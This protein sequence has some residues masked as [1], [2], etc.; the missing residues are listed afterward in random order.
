MA[1]PGATR[2]S[3]D[4]A[5]AARALLALQSLRNK[6]PA[7]SKRPTIPPMIREG[8]FSVFGL[9]QVQ[10]LAEDFED[11]YLLILRDVIRAP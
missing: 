5:C 1:L 7:G 11:F 2:S 4:R 3:S 6:Y 10:W 9:L 8:I